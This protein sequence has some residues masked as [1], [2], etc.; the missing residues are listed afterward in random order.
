[1]SISSIFKPTKK[2]NT[3]LLPLGELMPNPMQP[4][5]CF[6]EAEMI[7][8]CESIKQF[9][10]IQP[11]AVKRIEP[12]P[13]PMPQPKA[14][15][16]IIAGERR[17]RAARLAGLTH[18]PCIIHDAD[19]QESAMMA[20][21]ENLQRSDLSFFEEALA[22]QNLMLLSGKSQTELASTLSISQSTLS[23]KLRLLR[24][25]ERER[26]MIAENGLSERHARALV[27]I[28]S[29]R[30]RRPIMLE[31]I[32]NHLSAPDA[33]RLVDLHLNSNKTFKPSPKRKKKVKSVKGAIKDIRFLYNTIDKAVGILTAS[34]INADWCKDEQ[35]DKLTVKITVALRDNA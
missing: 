13:F 9:G 14:K 11:I 27:R 5:R 18:I 24:L 35:D 10:V 12:L 21:I 33:E 15:Y 26:L 3:V 4:R 1:M 20:L 7:A 25:S 8:L 6:D 29:E 23:N 31:I 22:M 32:N 28:E 30:E 17:W 2:E 16:E 34:G 19:R